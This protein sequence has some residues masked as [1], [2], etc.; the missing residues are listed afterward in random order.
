[1]ILQ[2]CLLLET[3]KFPV[4]PGEDEE[5]V[6]P[7]LYGKALCQYLEAALPAVGLQ[8]PFFCAEDWGWWLEVEYRTF[9]MG[10]CIYS[11]PEA[12]GSPGQYAILPSIQQ[13]RTWSWSK[14]RFLDHAPDVLAVID[15]VERVLKSDAEIT[16][17]SRHDDYP[18]A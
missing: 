18:L 17:V 6:N 14:F 2:S 11:D 12:D 10:L 13:A 4:M 7:G 3:R 8:V 9:R 16:A 5:L 1:M 15:L